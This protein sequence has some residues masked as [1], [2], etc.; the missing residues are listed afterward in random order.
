MSTYQLI[1]LDM[2]L[3]DSLQ[4]CTLATIW[5]LV[6]GLFSKVLSFLDQRGLNGIANDHTTLLARGSWK[7][8][9]SFCHL[10]GYKKVVSL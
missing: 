5:I 6:L 2:H 4:L 9:L 1:T 7:G 8:C 10:L 3:P